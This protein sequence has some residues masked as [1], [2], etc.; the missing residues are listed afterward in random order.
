MVDTLT[1]NDS[2]AFNYTDQQVS[3]IVQQLRASRWRE[4]DRLRVRRLLMDLAPPS[5]E[6]DED[7]TGTVVPDPFDESEL[8]IQTMIAEP[9]KATQF[10]ASRI[11]ANQP[12]VEI[13]PLSRDGRVTKKLDEIAAEEERLLHSLWDLAG[14]RKKQRRAAWAQSW[15]GGAWYLTLPLDVAWGLPS[16]RYF[17]ES[18]DE[19]DELRTTGGLSPITMPNP[20]TGEMQF[21]ESG[22]VWKERRKVAMRDR[23]MAA[24]SLFYLETFGPDVVYADFDR[25]DDEVKHA[26]IVQEVPAED[27]GPNTA[28]GRLAA[29]HAGITTDLESYGLTANKEGEIIGGIAS[30]EPTSMPDGHTRTGTWTLSIFVTREE[31]YYHVIPGT[32]G[33]RRSGKKGKKGKRGTGHSARVAASASSGTVIWAAKHGAIINGQPV[34]PLTP[35]PCIETELPGRWTTPVDQVFTLTPLINQ[36]ETLLSLGVSYNGIPRWFF[37]LPDGTTLRDPETGRPVLNNDPT[38]PGL[39]PAEAVAM[40]AEPRQLTI[41]VSSLLTLLDTYRE[42]MAD[43]MPSAAATGDA[44]SSGPA[45]ALRQLIEQQSD[46]LKEPVDHHAAAVQRVMWMWGGWLRSLDVPVMAYSAP[47]ARG[48]ERSARGL[49]EFNPDDFTD[50]FVIRQQTISS[51]DRIV[52]EQQGLELRAA[53]VIDDERLFAI[54][55]NDPDPRARVIDNYLQRIRDF[56]ILGDAAAVPPGSILETV[57]LAVQER[58]PLELAAENPVIADALA[59]EMAATTEAQQAQQPVGNVAEPAGI[60]QPGVGAPL[61]QAGTSETGGGGPLRPGAPA[62]AGAV[63]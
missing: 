22:D 34:C 27:F 7:G 14:G 23:A 56:V 10:Y 41:D 33:P 20:S 4:V 61:T 57:A 21:A 19:F 6:A 37:I 32:V 38:V 51:S 42:Q 52:S 50:S 29:D 63:S 8:I 17:D 49:I 43:Y 44:G 59:R 28:M 54:H 18:D 3:R 62:T 26:A 48:S 46:T 2:D 9:V 15:G 36:I 58:I 30:G 45:W 1:L 47:G 55:F 11:A 60:R 13:Q 24:R 25:A 16:R 12:Q 35:I 5:D 53:G 39:S 40:A 31:I